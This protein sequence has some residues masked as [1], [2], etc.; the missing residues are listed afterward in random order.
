M[1]ESCWEGEPWGGRGGRHDGVRWQRQVVAS[2]GS[3]RRQRQEAAS[4]GRASHRGGVICV[5][6]IVCNRLGRVHV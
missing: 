1:R 4:D 6:N 2:D 5:S 3:V